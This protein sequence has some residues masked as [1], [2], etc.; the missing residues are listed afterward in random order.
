MPWEKRLMP[1]LIVELCWLAWA[2]G[3][4]FLVLLPNS[5]IKPGIYPTLLGLNLS[6]QDEEECKQSK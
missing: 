4:H 6:L 2:T 5:V 1:S 3:A